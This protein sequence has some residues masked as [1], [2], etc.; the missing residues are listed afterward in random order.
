MSLSR[1]L[2]GASSLAFSDASPLGGQSPQAT[3]IGNLFGAA[4][5]ICAVIFALVVGVIVIALIR[6][7]HRADRQPSVVDGN[8]ALEVAWTVVPLLILIWLFAR[9][10][11][12]MRAADPP[13]DRAPD[14][15]VVAH[16]WW[17]EFQYPGSGAVT[18]NELHI[19]I[20]RPLLL[21]IES[22]DVVHDFWVPE[23]AR[24]LDAVPGRRGNIWM[25]AEAPGRYLGTCSEYCGAQHA[26]MRLL[27]VAHAPEE[28]AA[29]EREQAK[30]AAPPTSNLGL[31]GVQLFQQKSCAS[32]HAIRGTVDVARVAPDLTH[33]ATRE[34]LG[35]G[36]ITNTPENLRRWLEHP[37]AIKAGSHMPEVRL[38]APELDAVVAYFETLK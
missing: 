14:I 25:Q 19:P 37:Q 2:S 26:W 30:G 35:A 6:Y 12:T 18:A 13:A 38:T 23:L 15:V 22:S 31:E 9:T 34:T 1:A 32:C 5:I 4:L 27:V 10:A 36:V 24:K 17:W 21:A 28:F 7:R 16:Q 11:G 29:W 8:R 20:G 33:L 3:A